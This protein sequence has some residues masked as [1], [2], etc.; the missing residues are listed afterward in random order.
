MRHSNIPEEDILV[1]SHHTGVVVEQELAA[2]AAHTKNNLHIPH[3]HPAMSTKVTETLKSI[4]AKG[5]CMEV[6]STLG[7]QLATKQV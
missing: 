5:F 3:K 7:E 6:S 1:H 4:V 2:G